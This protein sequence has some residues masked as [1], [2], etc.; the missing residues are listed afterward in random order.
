MPPDDPP[1]LP[2]PPGNGLEGDDRSRFHHL[3]EGSEV[4]PLSWLLAL[5]NRDTNQPFLQNTE[6]FGLLADPNKGGQNPYGLPVGVTVAESSDLRF[7][8]VQMVGVNCAAC[9]VNDLYLK[10]ERVVRI[11]GAPNLLDLGSFYGEL[12]RDTEAVFLD[13]GKAWNFAQRLYGVYNP[14]E[15][16]ILVAG[17]IPDVAAVEGL[18][19][20]SDLKASGE[21]ERD[22]AARIAALHEQELAMPVLD[23]RKGVQLSHPDKRLPEFV[24]ETHPKPGES[25]KTVP[26]GIAAQLVAL[27]VKAL[28]EVKTGDLKALA[29]KKPLES[30]RLSQ[31]TPAAREAALGGALSHFVETVRL[32][33]ARAAFLIALSRSHAGRDTPSLFGRVDAFGGARNFIFPGQDLAL[34][35]PISYPHLWNLKQ[36]K[37]FHWDGNT[38]SLLERN[39]G[40]AIGLGAVFD[41]NTFSS[42]VLVNNIEELEGL[43][44][45]ITPP[46]WPAHAFGRI[47]ETKRA[48]GEVLFNAHCLKCHARLLPGEMVKDTMEPLDKVG[49]DPARAENF[50]RPV[51]GDQF[52]VALSDALKKITVAAG[53]TVSEKKEWRITKEYVSRPLVAPWATAPYLHNNS[54]PTLYHLLLPAA[55]RPKTFPLGH[56]EYD[57]VKLGYTTEAAGPPSVLFDTSLPGNSNVG[58]EYGV[59]DLKDEADRMALLEYLKSL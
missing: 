15:R 2:L 43:A 35:A 12:A 26:E 32:L 1:V 50:A 38:T 4:Y 41:P 30:S 21:L 6:R 37:W 45:K 57:P 56:R 31:L 47:D 52:D 20:L 42:T 58:H 55:N 11:D 14:A 8:K 13:A 19:K 3:A 39:V 51:N 9:H 25:P 16:S 22:L 23:L 53:G 10:G 29:A 27:R 7:A 49:T 48:R 24:K 5:T 59:A 17:R 33:R 36:I 18:G 34:N 44:G 46:V 28:G 54:V 40:Q